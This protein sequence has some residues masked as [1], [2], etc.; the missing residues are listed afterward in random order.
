MKNFAISIL[1]ELEII[2]FESHEITVNEGSGIKL[3]CE[4]SH[5]VPAPMITWLYGPTGDEEYDEDD[6]EEVVQ[7]QRVFVSPEGRSLKKTP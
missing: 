2:S 5:S 4:H 3:E 1:S 7:D 6:E